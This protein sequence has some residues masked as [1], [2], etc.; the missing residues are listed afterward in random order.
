[1]GILFDIKYYL[2]DKPKDW[3]Y[4]MKWLFK[5]LCNFRKELWNFR[6]WDF[7]YC[8]EMFARSLELLSEQIKNGHEENRSATKKTYAINELIMQLRKLSDD[9]DFGCFDEFFNGNKMTVSSEEFNK[10]YEENYTLKEKEKG[11][12]KD[13]HVKDMVNYQELKKELE[14]NKKR[15]T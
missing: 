7:G 4:N 15:K 3:Y 6:S 9:N 13:I 8:I 1:M 14:A 5:N 12:N 2:W 11:R 10:E